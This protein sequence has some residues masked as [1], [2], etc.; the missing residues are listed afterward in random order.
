M[1]DSQVQRQRK[2]RSK[3]SDQHKKRGFGQFQIPFVL[4]GLLPGRGLLGCDIQHLPAA[5]EAAVGANP[6]RQHRL[7]TVAAFGQ[8]GGADGIVGA[9]PVAAAL[10]Q[11]SLR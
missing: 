10:A 6:V 9:A 2:R 4:A 1:E 5:V 7:V 3:I 11:F 8:L